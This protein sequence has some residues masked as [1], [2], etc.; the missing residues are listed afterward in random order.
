MRRAG[1]GRGVQDT[2]KMPPDI[3]RRAYSIPEAAQICGVS[4][5]TL[6]RLLKEGKISTIKL[7]ARRLVP[8]ASIDT[9]LQSGA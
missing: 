9:L 8:E 1:I 2:V 6:Y 4:R 7:G 3:K 5:A